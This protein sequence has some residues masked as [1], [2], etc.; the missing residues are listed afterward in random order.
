MKLPEYKS[1]GGDIMDKPSRIWSVNE[2]TRYIKQLL[3]SD[4]ILQ[5]IWIRGEISNFKHHSAGHMYFTVKDENS[6]L[7]CVMFRSRNGSLAFVPADGMRVLVNGYVGLYE[8]NGQYQM[9]AEEMQPDGLGAL[10]LAYEQLKEKLEAEGLFS[11]ERKRRLP[12]LPQTVGIVTSP[13]GAA[14]RDMITVLR[15]RY[16]NIRIILAP[17]HVQG[18]EAPEEISR[19]L[20]LLSAVPGL[21]VV[22]VGRGGGSLE[23]LQPF[24]TE[25]VAR[26]V[27]ACRIPVVSAVGH[28][29]DFTLSD[30]AADVRAPTPSAAAEIVVPPKEELVRYLRSL[31]VKLVYT[32]KRR[33]ELEK[34]IFTRYLRSSVFRRPAARIAERRQ[35]V[36][37]MQQQLIRQMQHRQRLAGQAAAALA[38]RLDAL[39]PLGILARGYAVCRRSEDGAVIRRISDAT[40]AS[41]V[42]VLVS[43][44]RLHCRIMEIREEKIDGQKEAGDNGNAAV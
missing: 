17:A 41:L 28:E 3:V 13:T 42:D 29:T 1:V 33:L 26:A 19:A 20:E 16:P 2:L 43:D 31:Q 34:S 4:E 21:D 38:G 30:L 6:S 35:E 18:A 37:E 23:E 39:N 9:Y 25:T 32:A 14:L 8:K 10:H 27:A 44:G 40:G 15:R 5:N 7:R 22:I 11:P 24:N 12:F 36:G